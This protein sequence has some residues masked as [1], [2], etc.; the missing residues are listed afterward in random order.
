MSG[1]IQGYLTSIEI[2]PVKNLLVA[3]ANGEGQCATHHLQILAAGDVA[4]A[5]QAIPEPTCV[6]YVN[7]KGGEHPSLMAYQA[8]MRT[9][10]QCTVVDQHSCSS[11]TD[12]AKRA[13]DDAL[14]GQ[15]D[16]CGQVVINAS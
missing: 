2:I 14:G 8:S 12:L 16:A 5:L 9:W 15:I 6:K 7:T 10:E 13:Q 4:R 11:S 3:A 1:S